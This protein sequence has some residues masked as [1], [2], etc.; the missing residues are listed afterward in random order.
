VPTHVHAQ[1][2]GV[3]ASVVG[4]LS[5]RPNWGINELDFVFATLVVSEDSL[6]LGGL[7]RRVDTV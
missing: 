3:G 1:V 6:D 5:A 4:D 2:I 7:A